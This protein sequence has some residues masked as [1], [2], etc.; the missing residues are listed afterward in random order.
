LTASNA[1][2]DRSGSELKAM[3]QAPS[4]YKFVGADVDS[5]ELWI[6]SLFGP[7]FFFLFFFSH[8]MNKFD[9]TL[10]LMLC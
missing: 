2:E 7:H 8:F 5:Q 6:A 4:G 9:Q 3:I 1:Y 10:I